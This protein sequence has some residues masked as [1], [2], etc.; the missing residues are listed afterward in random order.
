MSLLDRRARP[1]PEI[2][3][4]LAAFGWQLECLEEEV[5]SWLAKAGDRSWSAIFANLFLHHFEDSV[6]ARMLEQISERTPVFIAFEPRRSALALCF[7]KLVRLIGCNPVTA[8]DAPVSVRGGF[9]DKE[10]SALWPAGNRGWKLREVRAGP[11][12]HLFFA[13]HS[14]SSR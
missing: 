9:R 3:Q 13:H 5:V 8:H 14:S 12:G 1:T 7:S 6:I 4:G 2:A 10:L 11:F